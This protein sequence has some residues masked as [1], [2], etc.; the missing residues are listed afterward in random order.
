MTINDIS[1]LDKLFNNHRFTCQ[2]EPVAATSEELV[3]VFGTQEPVRDQPDDRARTLLKLNWLKISHIRPDLT[4]SDQ[5]N[6]LSSLQQSAR[7]WLKSSVAAT[8]SEDR[9][10]VRWIIEKTRSYESKQQ[11]SQRVWQAVVLYNLGCRDLSFD[12]EGQIHWNDGITG[13]I[14]SAPDSVLDLIWSQRKYESY[15]ASFRQPDGTITRGKGRRRWYVYRLTLD[16]ASDKLFARRAQSKTEKVALIVASEIF[17]TQPQLPRDFYGGDEFQQACIDAQDQSFNHIL[18]LSP[19][20]GVISLDEIV[21]SE[22]S[23][24]EV[25]ERRIWYWQT[26][27]L[28]RL[29]MYL[30]GEPRLK[31]PELQDMDWWPWLNP[32]STY[33]F[34]VF[35]GGFPVR[36]LLDFV[37]HAHAQSPHNRPIITLAERRPGYNVDD[38]DEEMFVDG[39]GDFYEANS[40]FESALQ[41]MD[42]LLEW[43][44]EL[45]SL[46]NIF[47]PPTNETWELAPDEVLIPIRALVDA[48]IDIENLLDVLT[49]LQ[50]LLDRAIPLSA[51]VNANMIVSVLLQ[52]TH[53]LVHNDQDS[54]QELL[55]LFPEAVIHQYV[56]N[57]LQEV[58]QEDQLCACLT[59]AEQMQ[60]VALNIPSTMSDQL[61]IW[62]QTYISARMRHRLLGGTDTERSSQ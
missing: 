4:E 38:F 28:Q 39:E 62:L 57:A 16:P 31:G 14:G 59:L 27:A 15:A 33:E 11:I 21:P 6:L 41:D 1:I 18:V 25:L 35:G 54:I 56:E 58:N 47:V 20:H 51:L 29:G 7:A 26:Q 19:Q 50:L 30:F 9:E 3:H 46:V 44:A 34:T 10:Q 40:D 52:V 49:D 22:Q 32:K 45:V 12:V 43:S 8:S 53:S 60:L 13:R 36:I 5:L 2:V 42:Q 17:A 37:I 61:L 23:W 48:E 55:S 24:G